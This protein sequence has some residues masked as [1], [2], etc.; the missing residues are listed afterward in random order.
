METK[1]SSKAHKTVV[2]N[3]KEKSKHVNKLIKLSLEYVDKLTEVEKI[4]PVKLKFASKSQWDKAAIE[5][6]KENKA[7]L[8]ASVIFKKMK[9]VRKLIKE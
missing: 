1:P 4:R 2:A 8:E 9:K 3:N 7:L 5:K 6:A